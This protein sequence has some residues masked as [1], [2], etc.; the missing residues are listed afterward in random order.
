MKNKNIRLATIFEN[1]L[2]L[3]LCAGVCEKLLVLGSSPLFLSPNSVLVRWGRYRN[4]SHSQIVWTEFCCPMV[5]QIKCFHFTPPFFPRCLWL[6]I[7]VMRI[8]LQ[9]PTKP[10][11]ESDWLHCQSCEFVGR[12]NQASRSYSH[13]KTALSALFFQIARRN[14]Y[15][16]RLPFVYS[17]HD[18]SP[19]LWIFPNYRRL[20]FR[21]FCG[22][23]GYLFAFWDRLPHPARLPHTSVRLSWAHSLYDGK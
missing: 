18:F 11:I 4:L 23:Y 7:R 16:L 6:P 12:S 21:L 8:A 10:E 1:R 9:Y 15:R 14:I 2:R 22:V 20:W 19:V 17:L 13:E 3:Y 5:C